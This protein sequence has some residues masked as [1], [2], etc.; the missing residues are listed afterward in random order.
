MTQPNPDLVIVVM[1]QLN[2]AR[3]ALCSTGAAA[4]TPGGVDPRCAAQFAYATQ[5]VAHFWNAEGAGADTSEA[6]GAFCTVNFGDH[7]AQLE[8]RTAEN[9]Q[10]S[11]G[12]SK[13]M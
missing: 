9:G 1:M 5:I 10:R 13:R 8:D 6:S 3:R 4:L 11:A 12:T 2:G 7:S